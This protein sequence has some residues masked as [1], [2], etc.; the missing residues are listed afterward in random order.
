MDL[1]LTIMG[2]MGSGKSTL[3]K[4]IAKKMGVDFTD[5]DSYIEESTGKSIPSIFKKYGEDDFREIESQ[6]L[7]EVLLK[8]NQI[9][10]TGG[11]T[12]C[13]RNNLELIKTLSTSVYLQVSPEALVKRLL[14]SKNPRPLIQGKSNDDLLTY[15]QQKLKKREK[16][17]LEANYIVQSDQIQVEDLLTLIFF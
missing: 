13:H 5:L 4:Q 9:V 15:V 6:C 16:Y 14:R 10:A 2:F 8:P 7:R 17:Y 11:G 1:P 3:G 12:P